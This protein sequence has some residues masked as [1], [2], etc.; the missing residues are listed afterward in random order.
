MKRI[1][2]MQFNYEVFYDEPKSGI[3][4]PV[5][6]ID[7]SDL[8]RNRNF[9]MG[10]QIERGLRQYGFLTLTKAAKFLG[11]SKYYLK[12]RLKG[13]K[14]ITRK[15]DNTRFSVSCCLYHNGK[16]LDLWK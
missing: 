10:Y 16:K 2:N 7:W 14:N 9:L 5:I 6:L 1:E 15:S 12:R 4:Y 13:Y 8:T 3:F 11:R